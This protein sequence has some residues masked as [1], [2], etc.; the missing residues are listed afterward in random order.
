LGSATK[1]S[2]MEQNYF[3]IKAYSA[4]E[5]KTAAKDM[6]EYHDVYVNGNSPYKDGFG[7]GTLLHSAI[8]EPDKFDKESVMKPA[9]M[10][11]STTEGKQWKAANEGRMIVSDDDA[12]AI[13]GALKSLSLYHSDDYPFNVGS[14]N[15]LEF[16][17]EKT[18]KEMEVYQEEFDIADGLIRPI[19]MKP[20]AYFIYDGILIILDIKSMA[21]YDFENID[22][23]IKK[24]KYFIQAAW[25]TEILKKIL[26]CKEAIFFNLCIEKSGLYRVHAKSYRPDFLKEVY[27]YIPTYID[28]IEN[29]YEEI[30]RGDKLQCFKLPM[31]EFNDTHV[32]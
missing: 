23:T 20:D 16:L 11:F 18:S 21:T 28:E 32:R 25:Y 14:K 3:D 2:A 1:Q 6:V 15:M 12:E 24:Y 10:K 26:E 4:S 19:K 29:L 22:Y 30:E 9:G 27:S 31:S 13:R 5:I 8:L 17:R 7:L